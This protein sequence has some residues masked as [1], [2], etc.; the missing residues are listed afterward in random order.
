MDMN[1]NIYSRL[2]VCLLCITTVCSCKDLDEAPDNR[3]VI[4]TVDK[5]QQLL[6]SGYPAT[7]PAVICELSGDN[8][9]DNNVVVPYTHYDAF[10]EFHEQAYAWAD[11]DNYSTGDYDTPYDVWE[12]YYQ[13][14]AVANHAIQAMREMSNDPAHDPELSHSWGEAHILR[15]YLHFVLVNVFAEAYKNEAMSSAETGIPYVSEAENTV[16]VDYGDPKY[17]KSVAEVYR[18]IEKDIQEGIDLI[19]D[20]KYKVPAYHFNHN[21]ANAFAARFYLFKRDYDKCLKYANNALG[22]TPTLRDWKSI[23]RNTFDAMKNDYNDEKQ[24]WNFLL[25]ATYSLQWRML[26]GNARFAI[27]EGTNLKYDGKDWHIPSTLDITL[28]GTGPNWSPVLPAFSGMVYVNSAGQKYGGWLFRLDEYFEYTDKIAGIGYVHQIYQPFTADETLL[29]RAEAKLYLGNQAGAIQDLN[30][31]TSS[32]QATDELTLDRIKTKYNRT[33]RNNDFVSE[34]FDTIP[35]PPGDPLKYDTIWYSQKMGFEN[36]MKGDNL[37]VLDCILHF[38]RI[39]TIHEG[40]RWFDIKRYGIK[41]RHF[42][43]G[44]NEDAI[45]IDCLAWDDPRRVLQIPQN[46]LDAG[47]PRNRDNNSSV[48]SSGSGYLMP[49]FKGTPVRIGVKSE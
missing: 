21:A 46:V 20:S 27:N 8:L 25:Q 3:T 36:V 12:A 48:G 10:S 33:N 30:L 23:N 11:I 37:S 22:G 38:R 9:L 43:R 31:W 32:H 49:E 39:E 13:G 17:R 4:D 24:S 19:N 18:L 28:W 41:V 5:V 16:N 47:F 42:Y 29:C 2:L 1:K 26:F 45:H 40:L 44:A 34:L 15:A 6:T 14:I 35:L 7:S